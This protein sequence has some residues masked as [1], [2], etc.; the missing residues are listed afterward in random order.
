MNTYARRRETSAFSGSFVDQFSLQRIHSDSPIQ[1]E[2]EYIFHSSFHLTLSPP[3]SPEPHFLTLLEP[4]F[5]NYSQ[6][7][8][9]V[10]GL[11]CLRRSIRQTILYKSTRVDF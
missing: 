4:L 8:P 10:I 11:I 6:L 1:A 9:E 2:Q 5:V 3:G 7:F